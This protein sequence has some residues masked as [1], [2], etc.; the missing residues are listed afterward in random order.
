ML[1][2][3]VDVANEGQA[4]A[5]SKA[6]DLVEVNFKVVKILTE[7]RYPKEEWTLADASTIERLAFVV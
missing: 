5:N 3:S 6:A 4:H 2:L 1:T 7:T